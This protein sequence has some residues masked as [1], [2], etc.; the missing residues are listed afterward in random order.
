MSRERQFREAIQKAAVALAEHLHDGP[1]DCEATFKKVLA[2]L[3]T[4]DLGAALE[5]SE[6]EDTHGDQQA[7]RR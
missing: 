4:D 3:D 2:V 5:A 1:R 6:K 7:D